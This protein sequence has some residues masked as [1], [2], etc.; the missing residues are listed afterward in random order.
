MAPKARSSLCSGLFRC[1]PA[2]LRI[3]RTSDRSD[4][5]KNCRT[6]AEMSRKI[7]FFLITSVNEKDTWDF[8]RP[9][10][11]L[12][13]ARFRNR[14]CFRIIPSNLFRS[15]F[16][17]NPHPNDDSHNS[18]RVVAYAHSRHIIHHHSLHLVPPRPNRQAASRFLPQEQQQ[19]MLRRRLAGRLV[20]YNFTRKSSNSLCPK[21]SAAGCK[22]TGQVPKIPCTNT[23]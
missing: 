15:L 22:R 3:V 20:L 1:G 21:T 7:S 4:L 2:P 9:R 13:R 6:P 10:H 11:V 19:L 16:S 17:A 12:H 8:L 14:T 23:R 5:S 18:R